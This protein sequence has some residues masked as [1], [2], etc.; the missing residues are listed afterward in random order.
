MTNHAKSE[1][2]VTCGAA[3]GE[4]LR[5]LAQVIVELMITAG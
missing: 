1:S 4:S 3:S 5:D 2:S